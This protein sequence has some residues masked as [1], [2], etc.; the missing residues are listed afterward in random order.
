MLGD[1]HSS[2]TSNPINFTVRAML[3]QPLSVIRD[4]LTDGTRLFVTCDGDNVCDVL[5]FRVGFM[6][7]KAKIDKDFFPWFKGGGL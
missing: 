6:S 1:C 4:R 7:N 3:Y 5:V 2:M